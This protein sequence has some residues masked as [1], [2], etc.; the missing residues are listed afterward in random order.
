MLL[1]LHVHTEHKC[2]VVSGMCTA[3]LLV[4]VVFDWSSFCLRS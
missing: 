1:V 3:Y 2:F 4:Y